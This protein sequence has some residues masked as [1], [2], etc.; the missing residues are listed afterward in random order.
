MV[1]CAANRLMIWT[2]IPLHDFHTNANGT[3]N[4]LEATRNYTKESPFVFLSTNKVYGDNP[5]KIVIQESKT[6]WQDK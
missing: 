4:L 1:H 3:L 5:N 2:Q 6:R